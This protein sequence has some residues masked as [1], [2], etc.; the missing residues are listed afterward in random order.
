MRGIHSNVNV[1]RFYSSPL[2]LFFRTCVL[3][4]LCWYKSNR[5]R[6]LCSSPSLTVTEFHQE[7][8]QFRFRL[9][10]ETGRV[11]QL[12]T[13]CVRVHYLARHYFFQGDV[14]HQPV[15]R[16]HYDTFSRP[17]GHCCCC[18]RLRLAAHSSIVC[19]VLFHPIGATHNPQHDLTQNGAR[20]H[21]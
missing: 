18:V 21:Q 8:K 19:P 2:F 10:F 7:G 3:L 17:F 1:A 20:Q 9:A 6:P 11:F 5:T 16:C 14:H 12:F 13:Q 15:T 4:F